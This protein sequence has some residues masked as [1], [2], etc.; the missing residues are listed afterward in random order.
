MYVGST[1]NLMISSSAGL[2]RCLHTKNY[3]CA[4]VFLLLFWQS[5]Q[6]WSQYWIEY[7]KNF[8]CHFFVSV[9]WIFGPFVVLTVVTFFSSIT[10]S[11]KRTYLCSLLL[12]LANFYFMGQNS[13]GIKKFLSYKIENECVLFFELWQTTKTYIDTRP[14]K[15]L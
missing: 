2:K 8:F 7:F 11:L 3:C 1:L 12:Q 5:Y 6:Y 15:S 10:P 9:R 14:V 13:I 4:L